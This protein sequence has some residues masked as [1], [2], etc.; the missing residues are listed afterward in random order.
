V[1]TSLIN[2]RSHREEFKDYPYIK[3]FSIEC[4][5]TVHQVKTVFLPSLLGKLSLIDIFDKNSYCIEYK[6]VVEMNLLIVFLMAM[7]NKVWLLLIDQ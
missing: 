3:I 1:K 5:I 2:D 4:P 6:F 7:K